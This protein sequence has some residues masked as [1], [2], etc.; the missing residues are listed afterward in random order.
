MQ[1]NLDETL[2]AS[3]LSQNL[4]WPIKKRPFFPEWGR[5]HSEVRWKEK[6]EKKA[7]GVEGFGWQEVDEWSWFVV[8]C[9]Y[10][11]KLVMVLVRGKH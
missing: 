8:S 1:D 2:N 10:I 5:Q 9:C 3:K 6:V 11:E 7:I 4:V